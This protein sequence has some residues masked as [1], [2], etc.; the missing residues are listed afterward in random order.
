[1]ADSNDVLINNIEKLTDVASFPLWKFEITI[2]FES[3][4]LKDIVNG[5][6]TFASLTVDKEKD[7][8]SRKDA[9]ARQ[10][11]VGSLDKKHRAHILSCTTAAEMYTKLVG[12]FERDNEH[13]KTAS[14]EQF[15][16]Y[17]FD[18]SKDMASNLSHLENLRF[19]L[20]SLS[21]TDAK[22]ADRIDDAMLIAKITSCLPSNYDSFITSWN[23]APKEDKTLVNLTS[24]L[25]CKE[26]HKLNNNSNVSVAFYTKEKR[27]FL[28]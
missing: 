23:S 4:G 10:A 24:R 12:I 11:I 17:K 18:E 13:Q 7:D 20:N 6:S 8:W 28:H 2:F 27:N 3:K 26:L 21:K 9:R 25:L 14:Y 1:M 15:F 19:R 22:E 5:T 16:A